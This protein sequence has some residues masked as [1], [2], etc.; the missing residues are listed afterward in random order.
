MNARS[1][2]AALVLAGAALA[3]PAAE[4]LAQ[5]AKFP[6]RPVRVLVPV[7]V[8]SVADI[9]ARVI[10]AKLT[11]RWGQQVLVDNRPGAGGVVAAGIL[12]GA[13]PNG[14]TLMLHSIG[15][16]LNAAL[17]TKLPFDTLR[18][19]AGVAQVGSTPNVLVVSPE[20]GAKS[21]RDLIAMAK[22][23]PGQL[24]YASAG[25]GTGTHLLGEQFRLAAGIDL[26]HVPFK[27]TPEALS[28]LVAGRVQLF[29]APLSPALPLVRDRR[30]LALAVSTAQRAPA[31]PEVP[32]V[33]EATLPGFDFDFWLGL[34]A[35][36]KTP[37]ATIAALSAE[38]RQV[39]ELAD[40][41]ERLLAQGVTARYST[42]EEF[43]RFI[44]S[45]V[46]RITKIVKA[47]GVKVE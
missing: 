12:L 31:L 9:T 30:L 3:V 10:G 22:A 26:V 23:K 43:D 36:A 11:E 32:T 19:F 5:S 21:V 42:P 20:L 8:G 29:F 18:D 37:R 2:T 13:E 17:Y 7:S 6:Q 39:L 40:V 44:R 33:A 47:A 41:R 4:V 34:L 28:D 14:H 35:S 15:H 16:A 45:E 24:N 1:R 38:V 46:A 27:G 25:I